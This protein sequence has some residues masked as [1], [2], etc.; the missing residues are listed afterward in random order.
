MVAATVDLVRELGLSGLI[1]LDFV[2]E[3]GTSDASLIELN[4]RAPQMA[5]LSLG[6]SRDLPASLRAVLAGQPVQ[7]RPAA[8]DAEVI[9]LFPQEWRRD[10][11]SDF[12]RTAY[13]DVP[14]D[15]PELLRAC[16]AEPLVSRAYS[17]LSALRP[18]HARAA[19]RDRETA[20]ACS[21]PWEVRP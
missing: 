4:P 9:A 10:P 19:Q 13:L 21:A 12:L 15:E 5:H 11:L 14:W 2:L 8:T 18:R 3:E 17:A 6:Q 1:G 7:S 16:V 20:P